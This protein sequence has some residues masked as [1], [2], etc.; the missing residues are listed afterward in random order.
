MGF[1]RQ[2]YWSGL[3]FPSPRIYKEL[4]QII[5]KKKI[6]Q[7][8]RKIDKRLE[9]VLHKRKYPNSQEACEKVVNEMSH[10]GNMN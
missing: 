3:P 9:Q 1:P 2:E 6:K 7:F 5:R 8:K 10:W 4:I